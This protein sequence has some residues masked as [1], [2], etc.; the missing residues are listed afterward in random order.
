MYGHETSIGGIPPVQLHI[1]LHSPVQTINMVLFLCDNVRLKSL[2]SSLSA[3]VCN[4]YQ[5]VISRED[6]I[7]MC[8]VLV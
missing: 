7:C 5:H 8:L 1:K 2:C 3:A 6:K 4:L